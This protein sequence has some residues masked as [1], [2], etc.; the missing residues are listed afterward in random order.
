MWIII[1]RAWE[2]RALLGYFGKVIQ[3]SSKLVK[4]AQ[5]AKAIIIFYLGMFVSHTLFWSPN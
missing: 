2:S 5:T 1:F 3:Y 4:I